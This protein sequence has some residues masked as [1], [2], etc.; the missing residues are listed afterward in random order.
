MHVFIVLYI[1][2]RDISIITINFIHIR[3]LSCLWGM[4]VLFVDR[5]IAKNLFLWGGEGY[6]VI[7]GGGV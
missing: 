2:S 7:E 4:G 1:V 3:T 6:N 5:G